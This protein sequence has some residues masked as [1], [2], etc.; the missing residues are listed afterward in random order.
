M[1]EIKRFWVDFAEGRIT[2][3]DMLDRTEAEPALLDWLTNIADSKFRTYTTKKIEEENLTNYVTEEHPFHAKLQIEEFVHKGHGSKLG[4][5]LNIHSYFSRVLTTAF[6]DDGIVVDQTLDDRFMF[7]LDACPTYIGGPEVDH[8]LDEL[9]KEIPAELSKSKR[10]KMYKERV[11]ALFPLTDKKYPRWIQDAEWPISSS[12]KP[13]RFVKQKK[14]NG[15]IYAETLLTYYI[16][17]DVDTGEERTVE[18]FT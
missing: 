5:Y 10:I 4:R 6:P 3:P 9:L 18:Q 16:F 7:M 13:M 2:V 8:L 1:D 11:K 17:E 12:G 14:A 15:K